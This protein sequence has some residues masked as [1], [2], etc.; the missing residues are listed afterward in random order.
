MVS[1]G[2][3]KGQFEDRMLATGSVS[4]RGSKHRASGPKPRK[5]EELR[6]DYK[7]MWRVWIVVR[8]KHPEGRGIKDIGRGVYEELIDYILGIQQ[9]ARFNQTDLYT[10]AGKECGAVALPTSEDTRG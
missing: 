8:V 9:F 5:L 3:S 4:V 1:W 2:T 6:K 7:I 10:T